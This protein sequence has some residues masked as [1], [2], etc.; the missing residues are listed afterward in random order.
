MSAQYIVDPP[1]I[2]DAFESPEPETVN[3]WDAAVEGLEQAYN[4]PSW[5]DLGPPQDLRPINGLAAL[6]P[7]HEADA[8]GD[9]W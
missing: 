4:V 6:D 2:F 8:G 5:R 3:V 9:W 7:A 1:S